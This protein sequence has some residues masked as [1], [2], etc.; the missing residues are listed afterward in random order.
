MGDCQDP[1]D[2]CPAVLIYPDSGNAELEFKQDEGGRLTTSCKLIFDGTKLTL[3]DETGADRWELNTQ[4]SGDFT[5]HGML[6]LSN[7][8]GDQADGEIQSTGTVRITNGGAGHDIARFNQ[9][10]GPLI[11]RLRLTEHGELIWP[12]E[13]DHPVTIGESTG[14]EHKLL[15]LLDVN[16]NTIL[17]FRLDSDSNPLLRFE[18]AYD[19]SK[20]WSVKSG[21]GSGAAQSKLVI[22]NESD[23]QNRFL[24]TFDA[25]RDEGDLEVSNSIVPGNFLITGSS[26]TPPDP[27]DV[28]CLYLKKGASPALYVSFDAVGGGYEWRKVVLS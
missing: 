9:G 2:Y 14:A 10:P 21:D 11:A 17:E 18:R 22:R 16:A 7:A 4:S 15:S 12:S 19:S 24:L 27:D 25:D 6:N 26:V 8:D 3:Q 1:G 23:S 20:D 13:G 28:G 5:V